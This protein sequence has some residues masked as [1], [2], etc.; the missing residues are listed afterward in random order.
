MNPSFASITITPDQAA[1]IARQLYQVSG[2]IMPLPGELDFNFK[3]TDSRQSYILKISRPEVSPAYIDFQQALLDHVNASKTSVVCPGTVPAVD[4]KSVSRIVDDTGTPRLV[5]MLTWIDGRLWS[6]VNPVSDRLLESLGRQAGQVTSALRGFD[7]DLAHRDLAWDL[8]RADWTRD[9]RT[10]FSGKQR[11]IIDFFLH[12]FTQ[13]QP[14]YQGLRKS[15]V[16]NDANDNNV[17]VTEDR[18]HPEVAA[19][20]DYGDAVYTQTVNDLAVAVAYAVMGKPDPLAAALCVLKGYHSTF[21]LE[22]TELSLLHTLVAMRL[23]ISVTKSAINR[24]KEPE[25]TYL[26]ISEKPAWELLAQW[27]TLDEHLAHYSFRQICGMAPHPGEP[28]FLAWAETQHM[29]FS[30]LIGTTD[31]SSPVSPVPVPVDMGVGSPWLGHAKDYTDPD[32]LAFELSRL[33]Q[34]ENG[35]V[36]AGGYL[37][38]RAEPF[39]K[40]Y[41]AG[42]ETQ[43]AIRAEGNSG[44]I[45]RSLHLGTDVWAKPGTPVHALFDGRVIQICMEGHDGPAG[46]AALVLAHSISGKK[47]FYIFYGGL[48]PECLNRLDKDRTVEKGEVLGRVAARTATETRVPHLHFQVMLDRLEQSGTSPRVVFPDQREVWKSICPDPNLF[49]KDPALERKPA[50]DT[51]QVLSFRRRHLGK[52]LSLSYDTPLKIVRGSGAFLIDETGRPFLDTVNNVAHVGHEHPRV[53][54]AGQA[55]M[56]VLNT[57]TRYLHDS[58]NRFAEA[59]L[60]TFPD[61]LSVVHFVNS[62][63]EANELALRM[64]RAVTGHRDMI[65]VEVGYHGNTGACIDISSYKF[66]GKGGQGAPAHTHIVPLPDAFRGLYRGEDTGLQYAAH[67][68]EQIDRV[69]AAGRE[70]AGFIC[71]SIISC[72][73]QIELPDGYLKTAYDAVRKAGGVCIA[74]EVQVGCGRM[75][76]TFWAFELHGVVPDIVTIGKPIG[77]GHPL[78]AVVCTRKVAEAFANGMEYFNTF[79]GNPVS[80]AI[81]REVLQVIADE[82]LQENA[83]STGEYL[84]AGLRNLRTSFP[85]IGDVRGQ[86][87]FLGFELVDDRRRP[88][89][90]Q[91][92]YLANRMRDL[93]ILMSTDGRD[94]NVLKIKPP[95]VFSRTNADELLFRLE[96]VFG[97]NAMAV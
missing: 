72:G 11:E 8:A 14:D 6:K 71:E 16:H 87:L 18:V 50:P 52:S 31:P 74:D 25:N 51:G 64:A 37:E 4:G 76:Y 2:D 12:R 36:P 19:I 39:L 56:A 58:I 47:E 82:G 55:Q 29:R 49:F 26:Q 7:H 42:M 5:R 86:G 69:H 21:P 43:D 30:D 75:G 70:V 27:R 53:V 95:A 96:T 57:N 94:H 24:V 15:V 10:L 46:S 78:A 20:I 45:Y 84:K 62:G 89:G 48:D 83:R 65:A 67:V 68:R 13:I 28:E 73:G 79:G 3:I 54:K 97:E 17:V 35:A 22:E 77:N 63:S 88:L 93:G 23:V 90:A 81:G 44:P 33:S 59:L 60:A 41:E 80:C 9:H 92:E 85:I 91:A 34:Q 66:D 32:R 40:T 61:D 38:Y 1:Q